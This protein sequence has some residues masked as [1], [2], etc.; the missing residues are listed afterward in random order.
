M[1]DDV[2]VRE[3]GDNGLGVDARRAFEKG[4]F[5]FRRRHTRVVGESD[6]GDLDEWDRIRLCELSFDRYAASPVR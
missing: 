1:T 6:I 2:E 4:E 3:A 5:I